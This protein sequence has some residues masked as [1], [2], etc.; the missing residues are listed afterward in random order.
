MLRGI[1]SFTGGFVF[2][3]ATWT[4]DEANGHERTEQTP[5]RTPVKP[6]GHEVIPGIS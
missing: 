3:H 4:H 5:D 6:S 2:C 1:L